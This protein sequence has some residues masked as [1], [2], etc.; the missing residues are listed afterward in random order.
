MPE[1]DPFEGRLAAAVR[2]FADRADTRVDPVAVAGRAIGRRR[3]ASLAWLERPVPVPVSILLI[4]GLL[5][6]LL[7]WT[8]QV[9]APW[10]QRTSVVPLPAPT[11][12]ATPTATPVPITYPTGPAHVTGTSNFSASSG[13]E[14]KV[15]DVTQTRGIVLIDRATMSD[16]RV[17][18][19]A[20]GHLSVDA[21]GTVGPEWGTSRLENAGGAWEGTCTGAAWSDFNASA[22]SCW[23]V[24]S[25]AYQGYTYYFH[26]STAR[27]TGAV[28]G[29]IFP[30][31]PPAP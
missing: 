16:P 20:T 22:V 13:E 28:E 18:G 4:L 26:I 7:A 27:T 5:L 17:S 9:G 30:G 24:G 3:F 29:V 23:L 31:S 1:L 15:G 19:T 8:A 12:T 11:R 2:A 6:A 10:D 14:T 21:Y 25:G